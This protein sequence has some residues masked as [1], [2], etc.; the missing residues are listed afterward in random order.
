MKRALPLLLLAAACSDSEG[1]T[2][3]PEVTAP[4]TMAVS[5]PGG[6]LSV[7]F[8]EITR[9]DGTTFWIAT[10]EVTWEVYDLFFLRP[11]EEAEVDGI[12]G[13][14]KSVFPVTRGWGHDGMPALGMT[15]NAA[16]SFCAWL[17]GKELGRSFRLPTAEEWL[18]AAGD[19]PADWDAAAWHSGVAEEIPH[20]VGG[21]AANAHGL[22]DMA[23]NVAEWVVSDEENPLALGGS[24]LQGPGELGRDGRLQY[25]LTWQQRDPQWPKSVWWMS[26]AGYV[27][28]RL[29]TDDGP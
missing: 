21:K 4:R 9:A 27:G 14:S 10:T 8:A 17:N 20:L 1:P 25:E 11:D 7:D 2:P 12:T 22:H 23:G 18:L 6:E 5:M 13:P 3:A 26:D 29:V 15:Y 24:W 28:F 19:D 16:Q